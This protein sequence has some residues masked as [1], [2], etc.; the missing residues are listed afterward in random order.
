MNRRRNQ[1]D[2]TLGICYAA[3]LAT[4]ASLAVASAELRT[5]SRTQ[6]N[7][8]RNNHRQRSVNLKYLIEQGLG[9]F[10]R[11]GRTTSRYNFALRAATDFSTRGHLF[12]GCAHNP[13]R[14]R[15]I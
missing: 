4:D 2:S 8:Q 7:P 15:K 10:R 11:Q 5:R 14:V 1:Y 3:K 13:Y 12:A 9:A 6:E